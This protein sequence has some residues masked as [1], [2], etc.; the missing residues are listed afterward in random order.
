MSMLAIA[1]IAVGLILIFME[2][3]LI[4]GFGPI[5][6]VGGALI[7]IGVIIAGFTKG[8]WTA[9]IYSGITIA[10]VIPIC[11]VGFWVMPR[12]KFG[13]AFILGTSE[14]RETGFVSSS[15]E[16]VD[17]I[18]KTGLSVTS[19][20]PAG[21]VDID[22]NRLNVVTKGEFIEKGKQVEILDVKGSR[23]VVGTQEV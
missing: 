6:L 8:M 15:E 10:I 21:I 14:N 7:V 20:R 19:L 4:P 5:G 23:I 13:K 3:F 2:I 12:T 22:G 17:Y 18:G 1:L 16:L 9:V 11:A